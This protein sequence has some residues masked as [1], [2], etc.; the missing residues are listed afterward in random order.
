MTT[1]GLKPKTLTT[2]RVVKPGLFTGKVTP[3]NEDKIF[4]P[5]TI[6]EAERVY[7]T[8]VAKLVGKEPRTTGWSAG[9]DSDALSALGKIFVRILNSDGFKLNLNGWEIQYDQPEGMEKNYTAKYLYKD[10]EVWI[11]HDGVIYFSGPGVGNHLGSIVEAW[12]EELKRIHKEHL[13]HPFV[14][15]AGKCKDMQMQPLIITGE[16]VEY[17]WQE[18]Y[19]FD[20]YLGGSYL[21]DEDDGSRV[22]QMFEN[23]LDEQEFLKRAHLW[24]LS[25]LAVENIKEVIKVYVQ[26]KFTY[27]NRDPDF[28]IILGKVCENIIDNLKLSGIEDHALRWTSIFENVPVKYEDEEDGKVDALVKNQMDALGYI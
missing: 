13:I 24:Y 27:N 9:G 18:G 3:I 10:V 5:M 25:G 14:D 17:L 19:Q 22:L 8:L 15:P 4:L 26:L 21:P 6:A 12:S 16:I 28:P 1:T 11:S 2:T 23:G 20:D 7:H